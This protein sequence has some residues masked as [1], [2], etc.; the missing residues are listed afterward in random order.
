[1]FVCQT[2]L[3]LS[4]VNECKPLVSMWK[5]TVSIWDMMSLWLI[6]PLPLGHARRL[7]HADEGHQGVEAQVE[8]SSKV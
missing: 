1:M 4:K 5:L 8:I 7:G 3:K 2:R 6:P